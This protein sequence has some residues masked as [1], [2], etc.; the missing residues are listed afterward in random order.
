MMQI[1]LEPK[2]NG[3]NIT[4]K[5]GSNLDIS[6]VSSVQNFFST[7]WKQIFT[8]VL[9]LCIPNIDQNVHCAI[10]IDDADAS[11][12]QDQWVTYYR[13]ERS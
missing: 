13:K 1:L 3:R 7:P 2:N 9:S 10:S 12:S 4:T 6:Q 8:Y 5:K 11:W